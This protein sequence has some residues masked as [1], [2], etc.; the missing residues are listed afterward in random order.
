M[1]FILYDGETIEDWTKKCSTLNTLYQYPRDTIYPTTRVM[2]FLL[3][4]HD[5][6]VEGYTEQNWIIF[7]IPL[8]YLLLIQINR[9]VFKIVKISELFKSDI[10]IKKIK[11][12]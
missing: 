5:L 7:T 1:S 3:I 4:F 8:Y 9:C 10:S 11:Q 12:I 6:K 2:S